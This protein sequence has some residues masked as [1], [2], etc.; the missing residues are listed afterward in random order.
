MD[1]CVADVTV[2]PPQKVSTIPLGHCSAAVLYS[3]VCHNRSPF[4]FSLNLPH[5]PVGYRGVVPS[6]RLRYPINDRIRELFAVK[7]IADKRY[8]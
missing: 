8:S 2:C 3:D 6:Q 7:V 4:L 1:I 5:I